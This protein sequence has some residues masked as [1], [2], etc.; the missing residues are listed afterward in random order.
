[1]PPCRLNGFAGPA[2]RRGDMEKAMEIILHGQGNIY[3]F[4][5]GQVKEMRFDKIIRNGTLVLEHGTLNACLAIKRGKDSGNP[6]GWL[7]CG[8]G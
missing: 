6:A 7:R 4:R 8:C 1:M 5:E 2:I 3:D